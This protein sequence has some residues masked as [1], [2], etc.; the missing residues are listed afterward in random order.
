MA[1]QPD[2]RI[3][4]AGTGLRELRGFGAL[5]R[6]LP[7]GK[8]DPAFAEGG[9]LLDARF[10]PFSA[11]A[12][13]GDG[14]ILVGAPQRTSPDYAERLT[15]GRYLA[16]GRR[17]LGFG[18]GGAVKEPTGFVPTAILPRDD[19]RFVVAANAPYEPDAPWQGS[20][21][22]ARVYAADGSSFR[23]AGNVYAEAP[24][25]GPRSSEL[26]DLLA[27]PDSSLIGAG[28]L[29]QPGV[30]FLARFAPGAVSF[31][32]QSFGGGVGIVE[33][34][35]PPLPGSRPTALAD[36]GDRV[37]VVGAV[38][39]EM[40]VARF[41]G[42]GTV[43]SSFGAGGLAMLAI[44]GWLHAEANAVA[45]QPDGKIVVVG[46]SRRPASGSPP[47]R[48]CDPCS[49]AVAVRFTA[50][51]ALDP[52]FGSG[53]VARLAPLGGGPL[54][55]AGD[56]VA[57]LPGGKILVAAEPLGGRDT[58]FALA[59]FNA[60]GTL[61]PAFGDDGLVTTDTC[62]GSEAQKRRARCLPSARVGLRVGRLADGSLRLRTV[63]GSNIP[64]ARVMQAKLL[65]PKGLRF[66]SAFVK[67]TNECR[68][69]CGYGGGSNSHAEVKAFPGSVVF[70]RVSSPRLSF[71]LAGY[72]FQGGS[73][74]REARELEF[75]IAV[76][77]RPGEPWQ[78]VVRKDSV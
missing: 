63:V 52:A 61:D 67:T 75:R 32:D 12:L 33:V 10:N 20:V 64:R 2:G 19:G 68:R 62:P 21:G 73:A 66:R 77:F 60:D 16:S 17:D 69:L 44:D 42:D 36:A 8:L 28:A 76:R 40:F 43:D 31:Y 51:G 29:S 24:D 56:D 14:R 3:L 9:I 30:A 18:M 13:Q 70:N 74:L 34:A 41:K 72:A 6:Y 59:R 49:E 58:T 38:G 26:A 57:L 4:L 46:T 45:V 23:N 15:F 71:V 55:A 47:T 37:V 39:E 78:T 35:P 7:N 27:R 54:E 48:R 22:W 65:L 11:L 50:D 53:G 1:V 5:V 25:G